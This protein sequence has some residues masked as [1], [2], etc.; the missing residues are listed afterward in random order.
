MSKLSEA[1]A[2]ELLRK[3]TK[4]AKKR[5]RADAKVARDAAKAAEVAAKAADEAALLDLDGEVVDHDAVVPLESATSAPDDDASAVK[6]W[7]GEDDSIEFVDDD[8]LILSAKDIEKIL[9]ANNIPTGASRAIP[10]PLRAIRVA[11]SGIKVL[12]ITHQDAAGQDPLSDAELAALIG[13]EPSEAAGDTEDQVESADAEGAATE[14]ATSEGTGDEAKV[15]VPSAA[16]PFSWTWEPQVGVNGIGSGKNLRGKSTVLNV[17][18]WALSG[19]CANFQVDVKSWI[20]QVQVDWQVGT[21]HIRVAFN[22]DDGHPNG[23]VELIETTGDGTEK[24][25]ELGRF[26]GEDQFEGVMGSV[27]MTRLRLEE[28]PVWTVDRPVRHKWP[29]YASAFTVRADTLNPVVGNVTELG[30]R[31]LQMFVGTDWGPALAATS[32]ALGELKAAHDTAKEK[33]A[34]TGDVIAEARATAKAEVDRLAAELDKLPTDTPNVADIIAAASAATEHARTVHEL[35]R[36]LMVA[37]ANTDTIKLQLRTTR[38]RNHTIFEDKLATKFFHQM[39]PSRCP[40]CTSTVTPEQK[41]AETDS[42]ACSLCSKDLR[43]DEVDIANSGINPDAEGGD[44]DLPTDDIQALNDAL[45][46]AKDVAEALTTRITN[47]KANLAAAEAANQTAQKRIAAAEDRRKLELAAAHAQGALAAFGEASDPTVLDNVNPT[48]FAVLSAASDILQKWM[49]DGQNPLLATISQDIET[50]A[51]GFGADS[52]SDVQLG[53]GGSM[54]LNKHGKPVTYS[55]VTDGEMLRLKIATAV[56]LIKHGFV[57]G[58]GRHP[59][60]LVLD[61][62][63]AEEMPEEDLAVLVEALIDVAAKAEMQILVGTRNT[64]PLLGLLEEKNRVVAA[65]DKYLW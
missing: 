8:G 38:A 34:T 27:M 1:V 15:P 23:T 9:K 48:D 47:A 21:E 26:D 40:R 25:V 56:A 61:S 29:A 37:N 49:R 39:T 50:L 51:V 10:V 43:L 16:V 3:A 24:K 63:A 64:G 13:A 19:R 18:M 12:P 53:G 54:R 46:G 20:R 52:L 31:M 5:L 65:D 30:I 33:A 32:T 36:Q 41:A 58:V 2:A 59:G 55:K 7:D 6:V 17:V 45:T 4:N 22:N 57:E 62:P 44:I 14:D 28:I 60:F 42:H 11:F 35:E